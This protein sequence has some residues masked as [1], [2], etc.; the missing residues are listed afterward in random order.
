[1]RVVTSNEMREI[2]EKSFKEFGFTEAMVIE[3]VG[4][5]GADFIVSNFLEQDQFSEI[6]VMVGRG[7]NG[8]DG[9]SLIH[10]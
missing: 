1:M 6:V 9:L 5:R 8:A 10:I 3:N 7:N 2:E 4:L